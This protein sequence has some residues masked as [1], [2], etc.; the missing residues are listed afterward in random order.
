MKLNT[1]HSLKAQRPLLAAVFFTALSLFSSCKKE[2]GDL[3]LQVQPQED[4]LNGEVVDTF[5]LQSYT[6]LSDTLRSDELANNMVG[7]INDPL[8]GKLKAG[9]YTQVRLEANAPAFVPANIIVDSIVLSLAYQ[10]YYGQLSAQN[11]HVYEVLDTLYPD[12][13]YYNSSTPAI[14]PTDLVASG[15]STHTP[16]VVSYYHDAITGDSSAPQ[17]RLRLD[18]SLAQRFINEGG[19]PN[20]ADNNAFTNWFK[21]LYVTVDNP[22]QSSGQGGILYMDMLDPATKMTMYYRDINTGD[23]VRFTFLINDRSAR[24]TRTEHDRTGTLVEQQL[25]D[26][27]LGNSY[28]YLQGAAGLQAE[29]HIPYLKELVKDGPVIV[30]LAELILPVQYFEMDPYTPAPQIILYGIDDEGKSF[31]VLDITMGDLIFGGFYDAANKSYRF[32]IGRHI[33]QILKGD[34]ENNGLRLAVVASSI[35]ANRTIL[36][37]ASS[38]NRSKPSLKIIYTK[39]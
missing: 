26:S 23:T 38:D 35:S 28:F 2:D 27:T 25:N 14:D 8:F 19:S 16:D 12:S 9:F 24:F 4:Q 33:Q 29:L 15:Y 30:N 36:S 18:N 13:A 20:L 32:S 11:F 6:I 22:L 3:G 37:G 5:T 39:Y 7:S 21:G 34:I 1:T 17:L 31:T 10:S